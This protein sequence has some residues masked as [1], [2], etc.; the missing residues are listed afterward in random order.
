MMQG[1]SYYLPISI[2]KQDKTPV[3]PDDVSNVEVCIGKLIKD[4]V[5]GGISYSD[6]YWMFPLTQEETFK[7]TPFRVKAQVRVMWKSGDVEGVYLGEI[8]VRE[9]ISKEVL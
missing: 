8:C 7:M 3:T 1:D 2:L 5:S 9:S 4:K 6:G